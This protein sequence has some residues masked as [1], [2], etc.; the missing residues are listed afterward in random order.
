M[1]ISD[2]SLNTGQEQYKMIHRELIIVITH[3]Q[4][5]AFLSNVH[6]GLKYSCKPP[7]NT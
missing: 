6:N 2:T 4:V 1:P 3:A 5:E 7:G